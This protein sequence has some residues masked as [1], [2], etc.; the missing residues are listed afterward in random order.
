M[1]TVR[2][3]SILSVYVIVCSVQIAVFF[4][5]RG[6]L[7]KVRGSCVQV[8]LDEIFRSTTR[9]QG[10][11]E[12]VVGQFQ[13]LHAYDVRLCRVGVDV[14]LPFS[15]FSSLSVQSLTE[16]CFHRVCTFLLYIRDIRLCVCSSPYAIHVLF[17]LLVFPFSVSVVH[18]TQNQL[19]GRMNEFLRKRKT[20]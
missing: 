9:N 10:V 17:Y 19:P 2:R 1:S 8:F 20:L 12:G 16:V 5:R 6:F 11:R 15:A 13:R 4:G 3:K 18:L 7:T 14:R